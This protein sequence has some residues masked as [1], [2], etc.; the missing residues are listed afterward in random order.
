M[1][2]ASKLPAALALSFSRAVSEV[3]DPPAPGGQDRHLVLGDVT[4][5]EAAAGLVSIACAQPAA[6]VP[7]DRAQ[8]T[9]LTK[10]T[11]CTDCLAVHAAWQPVFAA[12][13]NGAVNE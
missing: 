7:Y 13:F 5:G 11:T 10:L 2:E 8:H 9:Y 12:S 1:T 6:A 3:N 4:D